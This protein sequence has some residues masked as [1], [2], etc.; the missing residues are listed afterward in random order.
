MLTV[1]SS[2]PGKARLPDCGG[3]GCRPRCHVAGCRPAESDHETFL[4]QRPRTDFGAGHS[5]GFVPLGATPERVATARNTLVQVARNLKPIIAVVV[6]VYDAAGDLA[7]DAEPCR[8]VCQSECRGRVRRVAIRE[9]EADQ[10]HLFSTDEPSEDV[11]DIGHCPAACCWVLQ[12]HDGKVIASTD[13]GA[14]PD[15]VASR[16]SRL[17]GASFLGG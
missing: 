11:V 14:I 5:G 1:S 16:H 15:A 2:G 3:G 12:R 17:L 7:P 4:R 8:T 9:I 10:R 6:P 13:N